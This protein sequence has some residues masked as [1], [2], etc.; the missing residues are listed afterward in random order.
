MNRLSVLIDVL[1]TPSH[2][3]CLRPETN[4]RP[5]VR[6]GV[7]SGEEDASHL[8]TTGSLTLEA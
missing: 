7:S 4:F 2:V 8:S 6:R 1:K 5:L 3:L